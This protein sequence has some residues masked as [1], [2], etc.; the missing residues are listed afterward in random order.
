MADN[1]WFKFYQNDWLAT[2]GELN[3][4]EQ[5]NKVKDMIKSYTFIQRKNNKAK[6]K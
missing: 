2:Q 6:D 5:W 4:D 1:P 3:G